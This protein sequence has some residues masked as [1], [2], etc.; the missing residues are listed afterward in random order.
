MMRGIHPNSAELPMTRN[1]PF[2]T[3]TM[4]SKYQHRNMTGIYLGLEGNV[5]P[6]IQRNVPPLA[7][8]RG[9]SQRIRTP[10]EQRRYKMVEG[11]R[12][13]EEKRGFVGQP[14]K[15]RRALGSPDPTSPTGT[16]RSMAAKK[17]GPGKTADRSRF[18]DLIKTNPRNYT[19]VVNNGVTRS[20][21][22][23]GLMSFAMEGG[24]GVNIAL[25]ETLADE[26]NRISTKD[27][28][29]NTA[30]EECFKKVCKGN[31][32]SLQSLLPHRRQQHHLQREQS[33][34]STGFTVRSYRNPNQA[35]IMANF[36][37]GNT[38][39]RPKTV[40]AEAFHSRPIVPSPY[41][42]RHYNSPYNKLTSSTSA[43]SLKSAVSLN[44]Y[45]SQIPGVNKV[46]AAPG[47]GG[48]TRSLKSRSAA[49]SESDVKLRGKLQGT[50][51]EITTVTNDDS[52]ETVIKEGNRQVQISMKVESGADPT[53]IQISTPTPRNNS[54]RSDP[55]T[56]SFTE[57]P[58]EEKM[59]DSKSKNDQN[60]E[61]ESIAFQV[62]DEDGR[63]GEVEID[64]H[65]E[66][67]G[68]PAPIKGNVRKASISEKVEKSRLSQAYIET[69][70]ED[71]E[72]RKMYLEKM[73]QE[74]AEIVQ[75]IGQTSDSTGPLEEHRDH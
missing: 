13:K 70:K 55:V 17:W 49:W 31:M 66:E 15:R 26:V 4:P 45:D 71:A 52:I 68:D 12:I 47:A 23:S 38:T 57:T 69:I 8:G 30:L 50:P 6:P 73:L 7:R 53:S 62:A 11:L 36:T 14:V 43:K 37:D 1:M 40:P 24:E 25:A 29:D 33:Q 42:F 3:K 21:N 59:M 39:T 2:E 27:E 72:Q 74:H 63:A 28:T 32:E 18:F 41:F 22:L 10:T 34:F 5:K 48:L 58:T 16:P 20:E 54:E 51:R 9:I 60:K 64:V 75:E 44:S 65:D 19:V 35:E 46:L 67:A 56:V 61:N